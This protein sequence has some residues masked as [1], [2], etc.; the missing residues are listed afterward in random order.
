MANT[1]VPQHSS[2]TS[3]NST[4]VLPRNDAFEVALKEFRDSVPDKDLARFK[5]TT[6]NDLYGEINRIQKDQDSRRELMHLS[7]IQSCL[8]AMTQ[9]GKV[10]E[11]FVNVSDVVAFVW[12]P[13]KFLLMVV[14]LSGRRQ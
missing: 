8:E 5:N 4:L 7:R 2:R 3:T 11:I 14:I 9:F 12:G 6:K 10:I 1:N 13:M